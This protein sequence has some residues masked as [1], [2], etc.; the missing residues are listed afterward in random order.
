VG[1]AYAFYLARSHPDVLRKESVYQN[2][3]PSSD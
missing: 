1:A 3:N 2:R